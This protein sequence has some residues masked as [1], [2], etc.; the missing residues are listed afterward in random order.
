MSEN[1]NKLLKISIEWQVENLLEI[2]RRIP[3]ELLS[4]IIHILGP[5]KKKRNSRYR[6]SKTECFVQRCTEKK[7]G[8]EDDAKCIMD[9]N[10][11][12]TNKVEC[13]A[14]TMECDKL[15]QWNLMSIVQG[16]L[17]KCNEIS[18]ETTD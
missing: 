8:Q 5:R 12:A 10:K 11:K 1:V 15:V 13:I 7:L 4:Y 3:I 9:N 6:S 16:L 2:L 17:S 18:K 14:Q